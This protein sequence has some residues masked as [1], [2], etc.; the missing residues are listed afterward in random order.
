MF[1]DLSGPCWPNADGD[2][3][4]RF[5]AVSLHIVCKPSVGCIRLIAYRTASSGIFVVVV[6]LLFFLRFVLFLFSN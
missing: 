1:E 4:T 5:V 3:W 2:R 6:I